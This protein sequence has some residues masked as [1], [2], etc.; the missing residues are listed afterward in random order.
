LA[1]DKEV[2]I[3]NLG[4]SSDKP[5]VGRIIEAAIPLFAMRGFTGVSVKEL[6]EAAG[7]NIALI[8]YYFGGKENLYAFILEKQ[9]GILREEIEVIRQQENT[10]LEKIERFI[11][12]VVTIHK[13]NPHL[14]RL[15]YNEITNPTKYF[16]A[17][18]KVEATRLQDFLTECIKAAVAEGQFRSDLDINCAVISL[19]NII[20]FNF[21]NRNLSEGLLPEQEDLAEYY[22]SQA[23]EIYLKGVSKF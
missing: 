15:F 7:V 1:T 10:P 20:K 12:A 13:K 5:T 2:L 21:I 17:I 9:M 8:S 3:L 16:V 19:L 22:V 11:Q 4:V 18:V 23:L 14:D 6:A